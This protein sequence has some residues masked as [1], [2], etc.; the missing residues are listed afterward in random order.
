MKIGIVCQ[1]F[2]PAIFE[3][4]IS[5]YSRLL[6][7]ALSARGHEVF[8]LTSTEF[9]KDQKSEEQEA[10]THVIRLPGPWNWTTV[11][12]MKKVV[13]DK[14]I[15]ALILE[16]SPASFK[17]SFR[18][19]WA[20]STFPCQKIISFHTLWGGGA[21][22][23]LISLLMLLGCNKIIATN[24]EIMHLLEKHLPFFLKKTYSIP[25]GSN[26][27]PAKFAKEKAN[28]VQP[29]ISFFG[30]L[31]PGKG[32][33]LILD[34]LQELTK[35]GRCFSFKFIGGGMLGLKSYE[36]EFRK[37]ILARGLQDTVEHLGL[38]PAEEVSKWIQASRFIFLPYESGL[39]DRRGSFMAAISHGKAVL[40]SPPVV[41]MPFLRNGVNALWPEIS[42]PAGYATLAEKLLDDEEML[43]RLEKGAGE[44]ARHFTW[45]DIA[46]DHELV[47]QVQSC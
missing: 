34:V 18:V 37:D 14:G 19:A 11:L 26:I 9:T 15:H 40:T 47:L 21:H 2:P 41:D 32:L 3:G 33:S 24:S 23:R 5:H 22:D 4:G 10:K 7:K 8:A 27:L 16:Y 38:I 13:L 12:D 39:S 20:F 42:T 1:N 46:R 17:S 44:L 43:V 29:I 45:A 6:A 31:Y 30:M 36:D 28:D 25:I 35:R